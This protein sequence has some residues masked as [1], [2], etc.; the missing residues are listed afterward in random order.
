MRTLAYCLATTALLG[1]CRTDK[2]PFE[3][4]ESWEA[5]V[6]DM[7]GDG[8]SSEEDCNDSD[9]VIYPG[10]EELCDG[11][12][13]NCDG[14]IDE[15][16]TSTFYADTDGD[17]FGDPDLTDE[18]CQIT[19]GWVTTGNDCDDGD[20]TTYPGASERCDRIDNDCD[21]DV[22]ED[23]LSLWYADV[24]EDGFG[25][26]YSILEECDPPSGYVS[27]DS[28]CDDSTPSAYPGAAEI[29]DEIDNDC[30]GVVDE[31]VTR[32][33]YADTDGDSWGQ[34]SD[35]TEACTQPSGYSES[36]GDCDDSNASV[37][38][39]A[40][41]ICNGIDDDCDGDID[42]DAEDATSFYIDADGDGYGDEDYEVES[43]D[44]PV[45]YVAD[46]SDCNDSSSA[47][48]PGATELCNGI[49]DDCDDDTDDEDSDISDASTWYID[50]DGDGYGSDRIEVIACEQPTDYVADDTDC[51]DTDEDVSPEGSEVCNGI[52]DD[53]DGDVDDEDADVTGVSTWYVDDDSD[54]FG[55]PD[56]SSESCEAS[57]GSVADDTDCD[58]AESEINPDAEEV[59]NDFDDDCD[60]DIDE[61]TSGL[62]TWYEDADSDGYGD[63]DGA[64]SEDCE[65]PSGYADNEDDCDDADADINPSVDEECNG[66]DDDCDSIA[67]SSSVCPCDVEYYDGDTDHPYMFCADAESWTT[68]QATCDDYGYHMLTIDD[69]SEN[70]WA[71]DTADTFS[72]TKWWIGLN[73][74]AT[75]GSFEWEDGTPFSYSNWSS[76]EP[77]NS[78]GGEDCAQI[79]RYH[80]SQTWNDEPCSNSFYFICEGW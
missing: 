42:G 61:G 20:E 78:G 70:T 79:N 11:V 33:W 63:P 25:D 32:T 39:D 17:G 21:G 44:L 60:G 64:T 50:Y 10:A 1:A 5:I 80:P 53:C 36:S 52:D 62:Q 35:T 9:S 22:D 74:R 12:D 56:R 65:Q 57:S 51:D 29:C 16:V 47:I 71:D 3:E 13:N 48:H 68:A 43:C 49:D 67:D 19:E 31:G 54:G 76:G 24:D 73:D 18:A 26:P 28:D 72:T 55:D 59:C 69:A 34:D 46:D 38:P 30:D 14:E 77:N 15:G 8:F 23:V 6:E 2:S 41:E 4:D 66:Y 75:E 40:T 58:D 7:D 37:N 27:D 45:G